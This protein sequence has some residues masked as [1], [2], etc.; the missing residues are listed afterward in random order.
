MREAT[1][2]T[3][4]LS[5]V[6]ERLNTLGS[7]DELSDDERA[8]VDKLRNEY[9]DLEARTRALAVADEADAAARLAGEDPDP[10][11]PELRELI[12]TASISDVFVASVEHR[13][14]D[15]ATK[16]LQDELG[17]GATSVP[18]E[19][20]WPRTPE[21]RTTG[22]TPA[23]T[24]VG[25]SQ[26]PII[27]AVFPMPAYQFLG[28]DT[29]T[30][31]TG[32]AV[33]T[34]LTTSLSPGRPAAG[35]DQAHS[36]GAFTATVITNERLQA[37]FFIRREDRAKLAGMEESL[38]ENLRMALDDSMDEAIVGGAD[39]GFLA[40]TSPGLTAP[41]APTTEADYAGYRG[42]VFD[43]NV[44]DGIYAMSA[45][46]VRVLFG[47]ATYAHAASK[48]RGASDNTDALSRLR[49]ETGGVRVSAHVPDPASNDQ[50]LVIAKDL[51]RR[52]SVAPIWQGIEI[53]T[54]EVTQA[55]AGEIV[56]TAV[57]L[58]GGLNV[59][60]TAGY[61]RKAVQLA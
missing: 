18:V 21:V 45:D 1:K 31:P 8:E 27:P 30:V 35:A 16:E 25:Q 13:S 12:E 51:S 55:K 32:D 44:V 26:Q 37:S 48:Y 57:M 22:Q 38:R 61:S 10:V 20:I 5:E 47:P 40:S 36:A 19:L 3:V 28:V 2:V 43:A 41:T 52:H 24:D 56:I 15:G 6:R 42:L 23:P 11:E 17:L 7:Q 53:I 50:G 9:T 58:W 49:A 4:R 33:Y 34:V 54:D 39:G 59:L 46:E 14:T 60:R 29:P